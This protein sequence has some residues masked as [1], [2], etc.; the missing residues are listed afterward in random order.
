MERCGLV[1][2]EIVLHEHDL[3][4]SAKVFVGQILEHLRIVQCGVAIGYLNMPPSFQWREQHG[5]VDYRYT[6]SRAGL[7]VLVWPIL[8]RGSP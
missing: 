2:A 1:R 8:I 5:Q 6:R 3:A 4:G 7:A